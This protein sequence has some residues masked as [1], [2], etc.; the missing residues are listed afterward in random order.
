MG[1]Q[2]FGQDLTSKQQKLL[3]SDIGRGSQWK[4]RT[5]TEQ[6]M[7]N[8]DL[9]RPHTCTH[10][11]THASTQGYLVY[12]QKAQKRNIRM[13]RMVYCSG[14]VICNFFFALFVVVQSLSH[15]QLFATPWT[16]ECL[17]SLSFTIYWSLLRLMSIES[18][19]SSNH[20]VLCRPLS[21]CLQSFPA[22]RFFLLSWFF[23]S[24][25]QSIGAS[26]FQYT[27]NVGQ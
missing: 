2:R 3:F 7:A 21:S 15:V 6:K 25:G 17:A 1:S 14:A 23:A 27:A 11:Y 12:T 16:E 22:S 13:F 20:L 8:K 4:C 26:A 5:E 10:L 19:M 9:S 24:G 18:V